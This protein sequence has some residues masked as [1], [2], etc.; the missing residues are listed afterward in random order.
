MEETVII[1]DFNLILL[2][3]QVLNIIFWIVVIYL[4]YKLLK[5]K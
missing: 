3:G 2:I 4:L 5:K 1:Q